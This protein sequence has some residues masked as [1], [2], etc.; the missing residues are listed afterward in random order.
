MLNLAVCDDNVDDLD[1]IIKYISIYEIRHNIDFKTYYFSDI[2][3][4]KEYMRQ[5][6]LLNI[7]LL[8]DVQMNANNGIDEVKLLRKNY[9]SKI[10]SVIFI[11]SYPEFVFDSFGANP[12]GY[13]CK[14]VVYEKLEKILSTILANFERDEREKKVI[15]IKDIDNNSTEII[16]EDKIIA[17]QVMNSYDRSI[18]ITMENK[19]I[20]IHNRLNDLKEKLNKKYFFQIYRS[21][22][23]NIRRV[24]T[25]KSGVVLMED[26]DIVLPLSRLRRKK[27]IDKLDS[28][29]LSGMN[30]SE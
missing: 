11:S 21:V 29:I 2:N 16:P 22:I 19:S 5:A 28:F 30:E 27:L 14:P 25:V 23:I 18:S 13:I 8:L 24:K 4:L 7:V 15:M 17:I 12:D 10:R 6:E 9:G 26:K 3:D 20:I 1:K